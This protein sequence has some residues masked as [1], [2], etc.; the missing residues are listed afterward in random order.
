MA[1]D[2]TMGL[3]GLTAGSRGTSAHLHATVPRL[4]ATN[5]T[6]HAH[7]GAGN[8]TRHAH[9]LGA[10]NHTRHHDR[11]NLVSQSAPHERDAR[12]PPR[13]SMPSGP[14]PP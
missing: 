12:P 1:T 6:R 10:G 9:L 8:H 11:D 4:L 7:L 14:S 5:H 2:T 3:L 13:L